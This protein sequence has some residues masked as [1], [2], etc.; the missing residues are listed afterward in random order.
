MC[1][2]NWSARGLYG[3]SWTMRGLGVEEAAA[4]AIGGLEW[5]WSV[6]VCALGAVD[7]F[8][9]GFGGSK[10]FGFG[11]EGSGIRGDPLEFCGTPLD[12]FRVDTVHAEGVES[13]A[14]FATE[15]SAA[16]GAVTGGLV[17][18]RGAGMVVGSELRGEHKVGFNDL[19]I[20]VP[21]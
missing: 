3:A 10:R 15:G 8:A 6:E 7:I 19:Y 20:R 4:D 21:R 1:I 16:E 5:F 12:G 9:R 17:A 18:R 2:A 14:T 13:E 11:G